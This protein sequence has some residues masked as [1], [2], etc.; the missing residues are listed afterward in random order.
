M[1]AVER[2]YPSFTRYPLS[3]LWQIHISLK[4]IVGI[5]EHANPKID[6]NVRIIGEVTPARELK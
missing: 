2:Y 4:N 3:E 6:R 1:K 5:I